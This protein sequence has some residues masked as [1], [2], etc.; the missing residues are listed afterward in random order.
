MFS[1]QFDGSCT[2]NDNS[3][4]LN[5]TG[6]MDKFNFN[7]DPRA[8]MHDQT[9]CTETLVCD[10]CDHGELCLTIPNIPD[11]DPS[12]HQR[13]RF[14]TDQCI[15]TCDHVP[16]FG[17]CNNRTFGC[18]EEEGITIHDGS[19]CDE[20][21]GY[22]MTLPVGEKHTECYTCQD[23]MQDPTSN[24]YQ[25]SLV[26]S[27]CDAGSVWNA[28]SITDD[29]KTTFGSLYSYSCYDRYTDRF[30][31]SILPL[32]DYF[33]DDNGRYVGDYNMHPEW[34]NDELQDDSSRR[35]WTSNNDLCSCKV[36]HRPLQQLVMMIQKTIIL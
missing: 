20:W 21:E 33:T 12:S 1:D 25:C 27:I 16:Q 35:R 36:G 28:S 5:K 22:G 29:V 10:F 26:D 3:E 2:W 30:D 11:T 32:E 4:P 34:C 15:F 8:T 6:C 24:N 7:Y 31:G 14:G 13:L 17:N 9:M 18:I 23:G 19:C